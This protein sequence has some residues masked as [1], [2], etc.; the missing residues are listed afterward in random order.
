MAVIKQYIPWIDW[1]KIFGIYLVTLGHGQLVSV[2]ARVLIYSFHMPL[3]FVLSGMLYKY[4]SFLE[5]IKKAFKSLVV[6]YFIISV[7]CLCY[8]L[9][10]KGLQGNITWMDVWSRVGAIFLGLGYE[11]NNWTPVSSPMWFVVA[12]LVIYLILSL[13]RNKYYDIAVLVI[14]IIISIILR[15]TDVDTLFP[16][17]SALMAMPFFVVGYI[18]KDFIINIDFKKLLVPALLMLPVWYIT[19][20]F[21][22]RVDMCGCNYGRSMIL[23][24]LI[25]LMACFIAISFCKIIR[26]GGGIFIRLGHILGHGL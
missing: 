13:S 1:A 26:V 2:D 15:K 9:V 18:F 21:N 5:T 12:L 6:P 19:A 10:L 4:R 8:Y 17:D 7:I 11:T 24:Y 25:G 3:F 22:G 16:I 23:F 20:V 14:S